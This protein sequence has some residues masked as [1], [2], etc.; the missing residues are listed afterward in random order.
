MT[1]ILFICHGNICRS[2]MAECIFKKLAAD[3][4]RG[5]EFLVAS[6]ATSDEE[7]FRGVG[8][9]VYPPARR[10][11]LRNG[12]DPGGKRARQMTKA[13]Y[14]AFDLLVLMDGNNRRN[15]L[16]LLGGDPDNKL[17][18]LGD[19]GAG[20]DV[21]DPW[22]SGDFDTAFDEILRGCRGLLKSL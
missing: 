3:A 1:K 10:V 16:R 13:D 12:F 20:H 22:Y 2:P 9:P 18:M 19:Y 8:N 6:A 4:G 11:L 7:I 14:D 15:A 21:A 5:D 17:R